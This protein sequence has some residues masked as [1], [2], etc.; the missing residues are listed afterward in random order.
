VMTLNSTTYGRAGEN[1]AKRYLKQKG[2]RILS[3]N[4]IAGGGE[5]D[6]VALHK[7]VLVF[8]EVKT[9]SSI[10]YGTPAEAVGEKKIACLRSAAAAF[11][12]EQ[13]KKG[14]V[15]VFFPL[16]IKIQKRYKTTRNDIIE[17]FLERNSKEPYK[18]NHMENA[19]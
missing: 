13:C 14:R 7:S 9:R 5:L 12:H 19:F 18:I 16:G 4:Y 3:Q 1:A 15:P 11:M 8:A 6:I 17:V 2:Y 10:G